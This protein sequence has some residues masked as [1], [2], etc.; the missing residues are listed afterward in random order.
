MINKK[1]VPRILGVIVLSFMFISCG[2]S[3]NAA[4]TCPVYP[5]YKNSKSFAGNSTKR[6]E[7]PSHGRIVGKKT[8]HRIIKKNPEQ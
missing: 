3:K 1:S 6:R 8:T 2:S 7:Y 4:I 5:Y